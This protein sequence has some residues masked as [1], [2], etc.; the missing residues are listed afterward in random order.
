LLLGFLAS[1]LFGFAEGPLLGLLA[2]MILA[3]L[4]PDR[5]GSCAL[6]PRPKSRD[7]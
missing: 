5:G 7:D 3:P 4:L 1:W 2:G 6:P